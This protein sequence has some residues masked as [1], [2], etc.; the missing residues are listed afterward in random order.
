[1]PL[2]ETTRDADAIE[3]VAWFGGIL[4]MLIGILFA[5]ITIGIWL[6]RKNQTRP[7]TSIL[8]KDQE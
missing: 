2:A 6:H 3:A 1:M 4:L 5:F 8:R 7:Y